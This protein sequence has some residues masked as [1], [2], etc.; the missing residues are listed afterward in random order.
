[1]RKAPSGNSVRSASS[2]MP[3]MK[4]ATRTSISVT[5]ARSF[6]PFSE[7]RGGRRAARTVVPSAG[8]TAAPLLRNGA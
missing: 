4:M 3:M 8:T 5:P 1:M 6:S 2:P 7:K